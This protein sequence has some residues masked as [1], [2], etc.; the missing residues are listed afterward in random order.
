MRIR[1]YELFLDL[2]FK[3]LKFDGRVV[4]DLE[5]EGDVA[6]NSLGLEILQVTYNGK[7]FRH[8]QT[9]EDLVVKSGPFAGRLEIMYRGLV[10]DNF[11]GLYKA[12]YGDTYVLSTQFEAAHARRLLPCAD[13]PAYKAEFKLAV[14]TDS[15]L[16][17]ISNMPV[18][19]VEVEGGRKTVTFRKTPRMSTYLLYLG[20]GKFDQSQSKLGELAITVA[21]T[22]GKARKANFAVDVTKESIKFYESYFGSAYQLPKLHLVGVPEFSAGAME[23]WGAITFREVYLFVDENTSIRIKKLVAEVIAHEVA[24]QWFG[25]LVT[26]KWWDDLWLNE[27]FATFMAY[28][29]VDG[30]NPQWNV[31]QDFLRADTATGMA[32]DSLRS[33]HPIEVQ[34][35]HPSE[36]EQIFDEISYSKGASVLRMIEAYTGPE[37]FM[38]GVRNYLDTYR[39]SNAT[40]DDLWSHLEKFSQA[41]VKGIMNEWIRKPGY[42]VLTVSFR[43]GKIVL[44]QERFLLSGT[45]ERGVWPVPVTARVN[46]R[47]ER[48]LLD[49]EE[50]HIDLHDGLQSLKL[51]VDQ[52]GFYRVYYDGLYD[53]VWKSN[54]SSSD[55]FGIVFDAFAFTIAGKM[56]YHDYLGLISRFIQENEYLPSYEVSDQLAFLY[57]ITPSVADMSSRFHRAQLEILS[58][59][60]DENSILLRG[61]MAYRLAMADLNYS[62]ELASKFQEYDKVE[63][64]MRQAVAAAYARATGDLEG[65]LKRYRES[66]S[67]EEKV[68]MLVA[69]VSFTEA[70]LVERSLAF[71]LSD[72]V[73]KQDL[74]SILLA[75]TRNPDSRDTVWSWLRSNLDR[76]SK[77]Y[78]GTGVVSRL[79]RDLLPFVGTG[80]VEEV[81]TFF[82]Q[83]KVA[84]A[85]KG[86][87][88]GLE[89]LRIY[90]RFLQSI[91][92]SRSE[93]VEAA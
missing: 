85:E 5:S 20:V 54:P 67:D 8:E 1:S 62:Q 69:L 24:H 80:R 36:I 37:N 12:P 60:T 52:T 33:T 93:A 77:L 38:K 64:D 51:N 15:D 6:L 25:N 53:H 46:G 3:G 44:R 88:G 75:S 21:T 18:E 13:E 87:E 55:M 11:V 72:E 70:P 29:V 63:P 14:R 65:V 48:F 73:K 92:Q 28:K 30:L 91:L 61:V 47:T 66:S 4:V 23:N 68:R 32:R 56:T 27:S 40:G 41:E 57:A 71:S 45:R 89:K 78:E 19:S 86:I 39:F 9:G 50:K 34:V 81:E 16:D 76:L 83:T 74:A 42:P 17:I 59:K 90:D 84:G 2:D 7:A 82:S 35:K 43:E 58:K 49:K 31:W 22:P 26:M 10:S 79:L